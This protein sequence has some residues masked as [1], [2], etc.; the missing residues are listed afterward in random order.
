MRSLK[1]YIAESVHT[2]DYTIKIAGEV[3]KNF[4]DLFK[5]NLKKFD[6]IEI[7]DPKSTPIQKD[8]YG[9]PDIKNEPVIII[10]AK[11]RYP[12]TET[13]IQQMA[14]LL[15]HNV[16]YVRMVSTAFDDSIN[17]EAAGYAN[18][19]SHSPVLNHIELEEQPGAKEAAKAYSNSYLD[20]IKAQAKDSKI[21]IPYAGK[22]TPDSF[23][24]FKPY[25]D[26]KQLGDKSPMTKIT[27]PAKP[28]TGAMKG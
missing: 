2:Y 12:A 9:F 24:P 6:P 4:L 5:F 3:D 27:L 17:S 26:D 14:Q 8:P 28:K 13:M 20:S 18:E 25:L 21:D 15:G 7:S 11:F 10:K 22:K 16:N 19:A 23:D 1:Q